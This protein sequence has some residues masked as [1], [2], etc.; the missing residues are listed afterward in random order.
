MSIPNFQA[1]LGSAWST[2]LIADSSPSPIADP[3]GRPGWSYTK[4]AGA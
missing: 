2:A 4:T 1:K 3:N